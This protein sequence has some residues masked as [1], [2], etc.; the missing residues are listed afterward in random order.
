MPEFLSHAPYLGIIVMLVLTGMGLPVPEEVIVIGAGVASSY[1][2]LNP[3]RAFAACL[4]G[5]LIGDGVMYAIGYHWGHGIFREHPRVVRFMTPARE[6]R[7]E[8]LIRKHGLKVFFLARFLVGL[9][10]PVYLTA[11]ILRVPFRRFLLVDACSAT[12]VIGLFFS[13]SY[14]YGQSIEK[15]IRGGQLWLTILAVSGALIG[16]GIYFWRRRRLIG[17]AKRAALRPP[18]APAE[19]VA[20]VGET[21]S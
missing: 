19:G 20:P 1:N 13:L 11:G 17:R 10:A 5:A 15:W 4:T 9:R 21:R 14:H 2:Q 8:H 12:A 7:M 18:Q 3:W 6:E 16:A